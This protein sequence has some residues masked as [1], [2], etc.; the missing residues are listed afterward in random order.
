MRNG[1]EPRSGIVL[2]ATLLSLMLTVGLALTVQA[3]ALANTKALKAL[4]AAQ[5]ED[6]A[7][8]SIRELIRPVVALSMIDPEDRDAVPLN[9]E[10][11]QVEFQGSR[12]KVSL[13]DVNGLVHPDLTPKHVA[14]QLLPQEWRDMT[15]ALSSNRSFDSLKMRAAQSGA[16]LKQINDLHDWLSTLGRGARLTARTLPQQYVRHSAVENARELVES[17]STVVLVRITNIAE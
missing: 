11:I 6:L 5:S 3:A 14:D 7:R 16:S 8:D 4:A 10:D 13:Q 17:Q 2:I 12:Y 9:G 15:S 1:R